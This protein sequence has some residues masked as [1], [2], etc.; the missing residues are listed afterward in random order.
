[1]DLNE[2]A[3]LLN[4][5][6]ERARIAIEEGI[7]LPRSKARVRLKAVSLRHG[8][9]IAQEDLDS[10]ITAFE[11][12]ETG[13]HPPVA[14]RRTLLIE[15]GY[16]CA[17]CRDNA[18]LEFH[19]MIEWSTLAHH[20]AEHMLAICANCH[21]KITRYGEPDLRAQQEV[22]RRL[23]ER[24]MS[25]VQPDQP[26]HI[27][28]AASWDTSFEEPQAYAEESPQQGAVTSG[29][30]N[31]NQGAI[32]GQSATADP[33]AARYQDVVRRIFANEITFVGPSPE[34]LEWLGSTL[35]APVPKTA[36]SQDCI[37][38]LRTARALTQIQRMTHLNAG[39]TD[40]VKTDRLLE[41][42]VNAMAELDYDIVSLEHRTG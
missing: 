17:V 31:A 8:Y 36:L 5:S 29:S 28:A 14:V 18:P 42:T 38:V 24:V 15:S 26:V 27:G 22:K 4:V 25:A 19:H 33:G 11:S 12:E 37:M 3:S 2:A 9:D 16:K 41:A 40:W 34:E 35:F 6:K 23:R 39:W 30:P 1:M 13:R 7:E 21:S 20:D 32:S 10:Y